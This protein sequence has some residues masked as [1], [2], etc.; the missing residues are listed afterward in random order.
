MCEMEFLQTQLR[1]AGSP[2]DQSMAALSWQLLHPADTQR[3]LN[4]EN[5][6]MKSQKGAIAKIMVPNLPTSKNH[7]L[8]LRDMLRNNTH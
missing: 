4:G 2:V 5:K 7:T 3:T 6:E 1:D 8:A